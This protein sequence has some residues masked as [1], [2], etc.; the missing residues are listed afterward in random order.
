VI[1]VQAENENFATTE[2]KP[3]ICTVSGVVDEVVAICGT[4]LKAAGESVK[5]GEALIGAYTLDEE[6]QSNKCLA[7]GFARIAATATLTVFFESESEDNAKKALSS[8]S[9]YSDEIVKRSYKVKPCDG[10]VNYEVTFTYIKTESIN[11]Q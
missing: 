3:L 4:P 9:L 8:A 6:G 11:I 5:A 7:V 10:G 2:Y 1:A